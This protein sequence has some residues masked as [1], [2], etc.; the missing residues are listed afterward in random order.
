MKIN[1]FIKTC[2]AVLLFAVVATSC[3]KAQETDE[4]FDAGRTIVKVLNGGTSDDPGVNKS[5][6]DFV[7]TPTVITVA[8]IRRDVPSTSELNKTMNVVVKDD[9]AIV[10]S[11]GYEHLDPSWYTIGA[12]T[13]RTGGQGGT[14]AIT[15]NPGEVAKQIQITITDATVLDPSV[16]Y[17]LGFTIVSADADGVVTTLGTVIA[18]IGAK[19]DYDGIYELT[20]QN[21]HPTSNPGYTGDV[22]TVHMVTSGANSVKIFWPLAGEFANPAV[23][24]GG[25]SY[26]GA[27]EPEYTVNTGTNKVTVQNAYV[28]ATTFYTMNPGYDSHYDPV[29]KT[30]Y[31]KWG[32]SYVAGNFDPAASREW[33]QVFVYQGPR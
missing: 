21:Y 32:Y 1:N 27:Q 30:M 23:L 10:T 2:S 17:A 19:N 12:E 9:S 8:D 16:V 14:Y 24:G 28:G 7:P 13:P 18:E 6:I 25:L 3:K 11:M 26:F 20:W 31:A 33:T 15:F 29:T 22:T 5:A 4:V